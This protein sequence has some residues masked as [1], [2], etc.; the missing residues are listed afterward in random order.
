[1]SLATSLLVQPLSTALG[2]EISGLDLREEL[3]AG[4]IDPLL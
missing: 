3:A 4:T 2:A 1:M